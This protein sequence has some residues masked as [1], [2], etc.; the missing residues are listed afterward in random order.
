MSKKAILVVSF[1]SSYKDA[2]ESCIEP[3]EQLIADTFTDYEVRRAFTSRIIVKKLKAQGMDI[4]SEIEAMDKLIDENFDEIYIQPLHTMPGFEYDKIRRIFYK[5]Y[6]LSDAK[7]VLGEPLI[8]RPE[9]YDLVIEGFKE[10]FCKLPEF[11]VDRWLFMGH[12]SVHFANALYCSMQMQLDL[13]GE[14]IDVATVEGF[15]SLDDIMDNLK[16][17]NIKKIG[18]APFMLVAGDHAKNDMAGDEE[19]SW[20]N[21]LRKEGFEVYPCIRGMGSFEVFQNLFVKKT[22]FL[23]ERLTNGEHI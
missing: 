13:A 19:D 10:S 6:H 2:R 21:I 18:L 17:R 15:P 5:Y 9:D 16:S 12:G 23:V 3:I 14:P 11:D 8:L 22:K 7:M 1:G 20:M 4:D